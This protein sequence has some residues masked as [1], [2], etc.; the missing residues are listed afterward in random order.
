MRDHVSFAFV[1]STLVLIHMLCIAFPVLLAVFYA[2]LPTRAPLVASTLE[3]YSIAVDKRY[4]PWIATLY[5]LLAARHVFRLAVIF[6]LSVCARRLRLRD[7]ASTSGESIFRSTTRRLTRWATRRTHL[8]ASSRRRK[9]LSFTALVQTTKASLR[10]LDVTDWNYDAWLVVRE[11]VESAFLSYQ[12]ARSSARVPDPR[13]NHVLVSLLLLNCW[14]MPLSQRLLGSSIVRVRLVCVVINLLLDLVMYL[15]LPV[16]LLARY[17]ADYD[18]ELGDFPA[19]CWYTETWFVRALNEWPWLVVSSFLDGVAKIFIGFSIDRHLG[20]VAKLVRPPL[21]RSSARVI[22]VAPCSEPA[23]GSSRRRS[24]GS[25]SKM[26]GSRVERVGRHLLAVWGAVILALHLHAASHRG[27]AM[28]RQHVRPWLSRQAACS[29][30]A[31]DCQGQAQQS[32]QLDTVLAG[33]NRHWLSYLSIRHCDGVTISPVFLTL[34]SLIA[35]KVYNSTLVH[36]GEDA[37]LSRTH[38]PRAMSILV[39]ASNVTAFPAGVATPA[40]PQSFGDIQFSRSNLTT[41]PDS[42]RDAWP[43]GLFLLLEDV[44]FSSVPPALE[45]LRPAFLSLAMNEISILP[46]RLLEN[47]NLLML[48]LNGNPIRALPE[49]IETT[50]PLVWLEVAG[51][52]LTDLPLSWLGPQQ[53]SLRVRAGD[54][55]L[56]RS[57]SEL[58][59]SSR[60]QRQRMLQLVDCSAIV[61][62]TSLMYYPVAMER[63]FNEMVT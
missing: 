62:T 32:R 6:R 24:V 51:T 50:P 40:F 49:P 15:V 34:E 3:I 33:V 57:L 48:S 14:S 18:A 9:R 37:A 13:I 44:G 25:T 26:V 55:P 28:C 41:L 22:A 60:A 61:D 16:A 7:P 4:F 23:K 21:H 53:S 56:C 46:P 36:W 8:D 39:I 17:Y 45:T 38:H 29:L 35:I 19:R 43:D 20:D 11:L 59:E 63:D 30:V 1:W 10:A 58:N 54:T 5:A 12:V 31:F 47:P 52:E 42:V 27:N 2:A